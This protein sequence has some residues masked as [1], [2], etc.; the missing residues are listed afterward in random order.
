MTCARSG[1]FHWDSKNLLDL[2]PAHQY[3]Q[4]NNEVNLFFRTDVFFSSKTKVADVCVLSFILYSYFHETEEFGINVENYTLVDLDGN[5]FITVG[6]LTQN[7]K[8]HCHY[9]I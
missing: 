7:G 6:N 3:L 4:K 8:Y 2:S 1:G 5:R 9:E